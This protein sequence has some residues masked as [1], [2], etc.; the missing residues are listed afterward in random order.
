MEQLINRGIEALY[1]NYLSGVPENKEEARLSG[2]SS[3]L[4]SMI[5][6]K[7][8]NYEIVGMYEEAARCAG[9]YA[10]VRAVIALMSNK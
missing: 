8:V 5:E 6:S 2:I 9:F 10:G 7:S 3:A 4:D 1:E